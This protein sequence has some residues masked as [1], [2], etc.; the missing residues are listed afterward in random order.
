MSQNATNLLLSR[1]Q[2]RCQPK[3]W[4]GQSYARARWH[5]YTRMHVCKCVIQCSQLCTYVRKQ[6]TKCILWRRLLVRAS[7][8][9]TTFHSCLSPLKKFYFSSS[10][11]LEVRS[12]IEQTT[13]QFNRVT[14]LAETPSFWCAHAYSWHSFEFGKMSLIQ[15]LSRT[16]TYRPLV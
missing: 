1:F 9:R 2:N 16:K 5:A 8:W 14:P 6:R 13:K 7:Q 15:W 4:Q 11:H 10:G 3:M 12:P